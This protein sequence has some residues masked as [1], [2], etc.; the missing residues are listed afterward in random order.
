MVGLG[1]RAGSKAIIATGEVRFTSGDGGDHAASRIEQASSYCG[2]STAG[3]II[4]PSGYCA[5]VAT[6]GAEYAPADSGFRAAGGVKIASG[7]GGVGPL[8]AFSAPPL[9]VENKPLAVLAKHP[10]TVEERP[11]AVLF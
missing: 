11:P 5:S 3:L 7:K 2:S 8:A 9:T 10:L 6:S 1:S 4:L